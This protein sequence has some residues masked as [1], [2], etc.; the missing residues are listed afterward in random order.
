MVNMTDSRTI[1]CVKDDKDCFEVLQFVLGGE[2][3]RVVS[4]ATSEEGL[5]LAKQN[6]FSAIVSGNRLASING[7]EI[8]RQVRTYNKQTPIV[9]FTASAYPKDRQA[10][11]AAGAND[12]LGK[13]NDLQRIAETI[14][15]L[16]RGQQSVELAVVDWCINCK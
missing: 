12:Y 4:C 7:V 15:R 10:G 2:G 3:F 1:L 6:N 9:F 13:P 16:C 5:Q 8:C 11:L 14:S